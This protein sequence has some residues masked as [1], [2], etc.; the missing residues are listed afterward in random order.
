MG[1][2]PTLWQETEIPQ[3][4]RFLTNP[5]VYR[6]EKKKSFIITVERLNRYKIQ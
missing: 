5:S 1:R 3:E 6:T 2:I 4:T